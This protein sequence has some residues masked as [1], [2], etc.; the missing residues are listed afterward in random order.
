[1]T[2]PKTVTIGGER[3]SLLDVPD[4]LADETDGLFSNFPDGVYHYDTIEF[5][6]NKR[7]SQKFFVQTSFDY[8]MRDDLRS[9]LPGFDRATTPLAT[10]PIG[11]NFQ[12]SPNPASGN[13][14]DTTTYHLQFLGRY[15][16]PW[17]IGFSANY[18]YQS[19]FNYSRIIPDCGCLNLSNFG[20]D[21]FVEPLSNNR[22]DGVGL[23]NFR[24]DK[25]IRVG[26]RAKITGMLDIYN[27]LNS[28]PVTNFNLNS[29]SA[30]KN[31]IAVLDPR[32]FMVGARLEF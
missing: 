13:R 1:V 26:G 17:D 9:A 18:R 24:L 12:L 25:G 8:Q 7:L 19:G 16:L 5:A 2:V 21:F 14:Q 6:Y 27:V 23:M 29:G 4:S 22:A 28:D 10:D 11:I 32:V 15:T 20:A 31:V 30:Y 3:F